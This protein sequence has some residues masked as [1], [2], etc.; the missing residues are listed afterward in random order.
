M[1]W[2][3]W[4][5][6]GA[7][8]LGTAFTGLVL[9]ALGA[10]AAFTTSGVARALSLAFA[11]IGVYI[12]YRGGWWFLANQLSPPG[13]LYHDW[14]TANRWTIWLAIIP[15]EAALIGL[16]VKVFKDRKLYEILLIG[17]VIG[18]YL[19]GGLLL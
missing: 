2:A 3:N 13:Q 18:A 12:G 11:M 16:Y 17:G 14:F 1:D 8:N 6:V 9:L 19:V 7:Y 15:M 10:R 4:D 5:Q